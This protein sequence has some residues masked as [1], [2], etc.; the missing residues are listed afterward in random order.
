M[1]GMATFRRWSPRERMGG[2][3]ISML[4]NSLESILE[5]SNQ[6]E[7]LSNVSST[8]LRSAARRW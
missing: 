7:S 2:A 4:S 5:M 6:I 3:S 8:S 1:G